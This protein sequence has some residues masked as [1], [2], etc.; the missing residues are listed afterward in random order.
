LPQSTETTRHLFEALLLALGI[1]DREDGKASEQMAAR[2]REATPKPPPWQDV[3]A[4]L[5]ICG[6][7]RPNPADVRPGGNAMANRRL[8]LG[9]AGE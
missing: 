2:T 5:R 7:G 3:R 6:L 4:R 8:A 1:G 9:G